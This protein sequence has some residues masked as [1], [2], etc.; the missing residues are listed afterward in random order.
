MASWAAHPCPI[1]NPEISA[2]P[3]GMLQDCFLK[4]IRQNTVLPR[5][6]A[7]HSSEITVFSSPVPALPRKAPSPMDSARGEG[8][9]MAVWGWVCLLIRR[10]FRLCRCELAQRGAAGQGWQKHKGL[11][12]LSRRL[13]RDK[14]LL[15]GNRLPGIG[16]TRC[17]SCASGQCQ[18]SDADASLA[19]FPSEEPRRD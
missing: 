3:A 14:I 1:Y 12:W 4:R 18:S 10:E 13:E 8:V 16:R 5:H 19:C 17:L 7:N 2:A 6:S 9:W 11:A 15:P